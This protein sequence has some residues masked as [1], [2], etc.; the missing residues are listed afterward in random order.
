[1]QSYYTDWKRL[2]LQCAEVSPQ[3]V[4]IN[5]EPD[6]D[7]VLM[8]HPS[9]CCNDAHLQA[10]VVASSG[11]T[12]LVG[13]EN[14]VSGFYGALAHLRDMYAP[15]VALGQDFS[16]WGPGDDLTIAL[17]NNPNYDWQSHAHTLSQWHNTLGGAWQISTSGSRPANFESLVASSSSVYSPGVLKGVGFE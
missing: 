15:N 13:L 3:H 6:L 7:G 1:M 16:I 11:I 5:V 2:L 9:N 17:R 14:S 4:L 12:E 10:A 8:Q